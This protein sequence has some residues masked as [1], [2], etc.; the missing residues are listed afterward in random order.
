MGIVREA[1]QVDHIVRPR[2]NVQ[3]QRSRENWQSLCHEHHLAKS[4]WERNGR[5]GPL[6]LGTA[7]DGYPVELKRGVVERDRS[8]GP[9]AWVVNG[10]DAAAHPVG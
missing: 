9:G 1:E 7:I 5:K 10:I 3:L 8:L 6:V 4:N 2:G